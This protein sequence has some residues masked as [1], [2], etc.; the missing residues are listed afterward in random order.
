MGKLVEAE[1]DIRTCLDDQAIQAPREYARVLAE[2]LAGQGKAFRGIHNG[3]SRTKRHPKDSETRDLVER[4][5][6]GSRQ[7]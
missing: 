6:A 4:L 5:Q 3:G 1:Q 7:K 2:T